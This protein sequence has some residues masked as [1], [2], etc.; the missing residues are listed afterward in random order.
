[1]SKAR[2]GLVMPRDDRHGR[3]IVRELQA[4]ASDRRQAFPAIVLGD[5]RFARFRCA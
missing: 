1:M 4:S 2:T 5:A 3:R